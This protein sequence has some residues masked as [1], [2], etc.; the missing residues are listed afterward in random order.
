LILDDGSKDN[1]PDILK[2]YAKY[3][4]VRIYRNKL[5]LGVGAARNRLIRLARGR[6][7]TPIDSD[8]IILPGNL[9]VLS[10]FLDQ[11]PSY[12]AVCP[13]MIVLELHNSKTGSNPYILYGKGDKAWDILENNVLHG[14][15]MIRRELLLK[16]GGY[17]ENVFSGEDWDMWL[18][19]SEISRIKF[20]KDRVYYIW[21]RHGRSLTRTSKSLINDRLEIQR[22]AIKRRYGREL[23]TY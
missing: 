4:G 10:K 12:G 2:Y 9:K 16:V 7:I 8:D 14:G 19:L 17:K 22:E 23:K 21:R 11:H 3:K 18:R 6:Y 13:G 15:S 5:N 20:I 1:T